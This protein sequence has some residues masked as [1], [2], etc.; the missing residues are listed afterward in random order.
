MSDRDEKLRL[1]RII[2]FGLLAEE[3]TV[4]LILLV[5]TL[6]SRVSALRPV[7]AAAILLKLVAGVGGGALSDRRRINAARSGHQFAHTE[8]QQ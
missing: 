6:H 3:A 1:G 2:G 7:Y 5:L 8:R 4:L